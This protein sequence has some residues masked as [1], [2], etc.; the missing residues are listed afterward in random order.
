MALARGITEATGSAYVSFGSVERG[1][2]CREID[3]SNPAERR[4]QLVAI[5]RDIHNLRNGDGHGQDSPDGGARR[6]NDFAIREA[7]GQAQVADM[8]RGLDRK[9][10]REDARRA[11]G[12]DVV[13]AGA[14][15]R[16]VRPLGPGVCAWYQ[17]DEWKHRH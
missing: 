12:G 6:D 11:Q 1:P 15:Y 5:G 17:R 8:A 9:K 16:T 14:F 2:A 13:V 7:D 10:H 4:P 3:L